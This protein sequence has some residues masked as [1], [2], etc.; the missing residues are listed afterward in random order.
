MPEQHPNTTASD[1]PV[2]GAG[3]GFRL[4]LVEQL[5]ETP[6]A[7]VDFMEIAPENWLHV[8]GLRGRRLREFTERYPFVCHGL[9]LSIGGPAPLDD[10][11][12]ADLKGFLDL[13]GIRAYTEH[14]SYC[15]DT[16]QLYDLMPIP[17]TAEAV[18]YVAA[19]IRHVQDVLERRIGMENVST[20]AMPG[21]DMTELE[22]LNAV[23]ERADCNL[24]LDIN[25]IVVNS[26]NHGFDAAEYL[27]GIPAERIVYAH[28]AGHYR[29][30]DDLRIDTHGED[31]ETEVWDL[32]ER[33]YARYGVFPTLL[34][35]DFNIPPLPQLL[36]EVD[37]IVQ[38]QQHHQRRIA[39]HGGADVA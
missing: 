13:H 4:E 18:D 8:G 21:G 5:R 26:H 6:P 9:S 23:I 37:G 39:A 31:I 19:R 28:I 22:F 36:H 14:L 7:L 10:G 2:Q 20:Y 25:N 27:A 17:F 38:R 12:L 33:A 11:F 3:L 30:A 34:E 24:H 1:Y 32:L 16:G 29:E 35:R 15:G